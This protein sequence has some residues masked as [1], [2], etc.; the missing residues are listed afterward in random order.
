MAILNFSRLLK[1]ARLLRCACH[2][3]LRRT[4]KYASFR[5]TARALHPV[6]FEQPLKKQFLL[7]FKPV[8]TLARMISDGHPDLIWQDRLTTCCF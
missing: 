3:S 6:F 7:K 2:S 4:D 5:M 1:N 8:I